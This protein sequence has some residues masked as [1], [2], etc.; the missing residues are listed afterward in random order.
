MAEQELCGCLSPELPNGE[1]WSCVLPDGHTESCESDRAR[2]VW[3]KWPK[4]PSDVRDTVTVSPETM[5]L[6]EKAVAESDAL[7]GKPYTMVGP[8]TFVAMKDKPIVIVRQED[9][10]GRR[11]TDFCEL[12]VSPGINGPAF[13]KE[14][15]EALAGDPREGT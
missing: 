3:I 12:S 6:L 9:S 11:H 7:R 1:R 4:P 13:A 14:I 8:R 10:L 15:A 2:G 5:A